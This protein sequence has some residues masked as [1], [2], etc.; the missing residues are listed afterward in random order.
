[1]P[2][3]KM[4]FIRQRMVNKQRTDIEL[5]QLK[6]GIEAVFN[7]NNIDNDCD[8]I[9]RQLS[10]YRETVRESLGQGNYTEAV[11]ILLEVLESLTYHFVKDEHY[12]YFD[13]MYSPDYVCQDMMKTVIDAIKSGNVPSTELQRLK[14]VLE[15]LK[16]TEA[17]EDYGVP[18]ALNVW[19][20][21]KI[22]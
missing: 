7:E 3:E 16:H 12:D 15:K 6:T 11:T 14:G 2:S 5:T 9:A 22:L 18:Y 21:F 17:Y 8:T 1:M 13:D 4:R 19:E 10:P 20:K